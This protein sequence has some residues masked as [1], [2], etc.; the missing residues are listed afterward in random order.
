MSWLV[1]RSSSASCLTPHVPWFC[2][3]SGGLTF[4]WT[5]SAAFLSDKDLNKTDSSSVQALGPS[6]SAEFELKLSPCPP[7]PA[8]FSCW[9]RM[10]LMFTFQTSNMAA[11]KWGARGLQPG[12]GNADAG[13]CCVRV[14][15]YACV[16]RAVGRGIHE[17]ERAYGSLKPEQGWSLLCRHCI[18]CSVSHTLGC[19]VQ[20]ERK[21]HIIHFSICCSVSAGLLWA[22]NCFEF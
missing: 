2:M 3:N 4:I 9:R 20:E 19:L 11:Q 17:S 15:G 16:C 10:I 18:D 21:C 22:T 1:R 7:E 14:S 13:L 5:E 6:G 8:R 12:V